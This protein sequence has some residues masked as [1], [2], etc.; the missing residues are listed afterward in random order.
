MRKIF[1]FL[2][3]SI[4]LFTTSIYAQTK[5]VTG[6]VTASDTKL[7]ISSATVKLKGHNAGSV[8]DNNGNYSVSVK[9]GD[10][11]EYIAVGYITKESTV[12]ESDQIDV[13]LTPDEKNMGDVVVTAYGTQRAKKGL[14]Y[15]VQTV[16][17]EEIAETQRD[18]WI[19][20]LSGR[21]AGANITPSSGTPGAST[22]IVLRG[23]VSLG[24]NNQP[25]FVVDGVPYDNQTMN[26][27]N[28]VG[29]AAG[30][31]RNS[32]YTN[33]AADINPND[34]ESVSILK[35]PEATAL[36]GSD[37]ASG[38]IVITTKKGRKGRP[39]V[40]YDNSFRIEHLYRFPQTQKIYGRGLNGVSDVTST[41]NPFSAGPF[42]AY[43]G[44]KYD[45]TTRLFDNV[46]AF[47]KDGF[48]QR[49]NLNVDGGGDIATYRFSLS[50]L[51]QEGV[52][53][54]TGF[55]Q[56][57]AKLTGTVNLSSKLKFTSSFAY[58]N[59]TNDKATKG[60]GG[61][62][63]DLLNFPADIDVTQY[64][65]ADGTRRLFRPNSTSNTSEFD[66]P[67]WDVN[68]NRSQDKIDRITSN[69]TLNYTPTS[70]L[71]LSNILGM[72]FYAQTGY[73][74]VHPLS[75]YG[76][77]TYG[78]Y[79]MV[80]QN[81]RNI[82]N[83]STATAR[84]TTG[85]FN[86]SLMFGFAID[87]NSTT[88]NS[89][90]G[91]R[92]YEMNFSSINNTDPISRDAKNTI[93]NDRKTRI[94]ANYSIDYN[95]LLFLSFAGSREGNSKLMSRTIDK[96]PYYNFGS[97]SISFVFSDLEGVKEQLPWFSFGKLRASY[98]TTGKGPGLPYKIDNTFT[99]QITTGGGY[100]YDVTGNNYN[101]KPEYTANLEYGAE[102]RFLKD[103]VSLD[104][105]RYSLESRDQ[106]IA[107]RYSYG[108]G[109]VIKYLNGG[110]VENK[111]IEAILNI[112]AIQNNNFT[113][114]IT[115]NFDRNRGKV[116]QMPADLPTYYDSDTWIF[117]NLRSQM[118]AGASPYN[119]ASY[120]VLRNAEGKVILSSTSGLPLN[121]GDFVVV[122][123][124]Q[125]D[126]KVGLI[127]TF[128]YK[129][130]SLNF[131]LDF[132][133][134]GDVWNG[135]EYFL[136]LTGASTRTLNRE[137]SIIIDG[138]L[139]DG[140]QNTTT[141]TYN[142][143]AITPF[144]RSDYYTSTTAVTE[145][146]FIE[147]VNWMRLRDATI[148]YM[149]PSKWLSGAKFIRSASV[150][151]TGTELFMITNYT[152]ADPSVSATTAASRGAGGV[153]IDYGALSTPRGLNFGVKLLF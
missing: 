74:L 47:F 110:R 128:T 67:L 23:P 2:V 137:N 29:N 136:Y 95:K 57:S 27:E 8:T 146:D 28:L 79:S 14:G 41:V 135:N 145:A 77:S 86:H 17:G 118:F 131:N 26:Q 104:I 92:F 52:V 119:L 107:A 1:V 16:G 114:N 60:A 122:G 126:F 112:K 10:V 7:P 24:G 11:L 71:T 35:G 46:K 6:T 12:G 100:A 138:V 49:H 66:N 13:E 89:Q 105:T 90:K 85:I 129:N 72:D 134:G 111:G 48:T 148:T 31:N 3:L 61:Y 69:F 99:S 42:Y 56:L 101:L 103:R 50:Y 153:G 39:V 54:M 82:N 106:I 87:N 88:I 19:N 9:R 34:I 65:N 44:D 76:A 58:V 113:W 123:D 121:S 94:F 93:M 18:N 139:N 150:F 152:G 120:S 149:L 80:E 21:V 151:V 98:G 78:S 68:K 59:S 51:D 20:A 75:R 115:A 36:Y 141:P 15:Q 96:N 143:I 117:G 144:N 38:A 116:I 33:R 140:M 133:K 25:L 53:P 62:L 70:W 32:D 84:A 64:L 73:S 37:G 30:A 108:S 81:T 127:N 124:R 4:T 142:K 83:V 45:D 109:F 40:G 130:L 97:A 55:E 91:E 5:T 132:R 147:S 102:L 22:T 63:M 43:F 125:P